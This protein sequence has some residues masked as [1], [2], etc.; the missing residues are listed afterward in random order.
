MQIEYG[1]LLAA[2]KNYNGNQLCV[3][4]KIEFFCSP[5]G[6]FITNE[7]DC[8][9]LTMTD[10]IFILESFAIG[11]AV[12]II[13]EC[14]NSCKFVSKQCPRNIEREQCLTSQIEFQHDYS[15]SMYFLNEYCVNQ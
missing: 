7:L 1:Q 8:P 13:H 15:N 11:N 9:L 12:S 14:S 4:R 2:A 10:N 3:I 5:L 6:D